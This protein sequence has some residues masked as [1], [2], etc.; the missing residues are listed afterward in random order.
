MFL[1]CMFSPLYKT[2]YGAEFRGKRCS[3]S[4]DL[5]ILEG[6]RQ[7]MEDATTKLLDVFISSLVCV[8]RDLTHEMISLAGL[9]VLW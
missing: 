6:K 8:R 5:R 1:V 3:K 9:D 4:Y 2:R 7:V